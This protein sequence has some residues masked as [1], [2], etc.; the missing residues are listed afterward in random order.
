MIPF[1]SKLDLYHEYYSATKNEMLTF[2]YKCKYGPITGSPPP[3]P[4]TFER[5]SCETRV[6]T[7]CQG[8]IKYFKQKW[9]LI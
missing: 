9:G 1:Y 3:P 8:N 5:Q 7:L 2:Y 6:G 4:Y